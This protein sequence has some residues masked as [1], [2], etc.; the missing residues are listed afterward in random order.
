MSKS[1]NYVNYVYR[2]AVDTQVHYL[3]Q[4]RPPF[5]LS[6]LLTPAITFVGGAGAKYIVQDSG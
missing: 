1:F 2:T 3:S 5:F 6:V 4:S